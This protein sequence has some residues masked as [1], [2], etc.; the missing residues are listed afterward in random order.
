MDQLVTTVRDYEWL[1][2]IREQKAS[3]LTIKAWC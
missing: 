3:G 2:M 1:T